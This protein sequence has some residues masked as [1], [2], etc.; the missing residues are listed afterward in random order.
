[1]ARKHKRSRRGLGSSTAIHT[2]QATYASE[3]IGYT[4]AQLTNKTRNGKCGAAAA[5]Y[6]EMMK[7]VG[8]YEAHK[9]A[10]GRPSAPSHGA[11]VHKATTEFTK[12]CLVNHNNGLGRR[13]RR[14]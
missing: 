1:M 14:R 11:L 9:R 3:N 2:Q 7:F 6:G 12:T 13:H 8:E 10:G 5:I 4:V